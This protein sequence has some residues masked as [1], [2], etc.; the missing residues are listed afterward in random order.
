MQE[1]L[2]NLILLISKQQ[3]LLS[4]PKADR[5]RRDREPVSSDCERSIAALLLHIDL[6][7][8]R[9]FQLGSE[10]LADVARAFRFPS[11][12][13]VIALQRWAAQ[14]LCH[15]PTCPAQTLYCNTMITIG[16]SICTVKIAV[17]PSFRA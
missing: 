10:V 14:N 16:S 11:K 7:G 3:A 12:D 9:L 4:K 15:V 8:D 17:A 13:T 1:M 6:R 2:L 5:E